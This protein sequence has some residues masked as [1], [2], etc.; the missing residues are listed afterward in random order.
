MVCWKVEIVKGARAAGRWSLVPSLAASS[1]PPTRAVHIPA[2]GHASVGL[3]SGGKAYWQSFFIHAP[4]KIDSSEYRG[5]P[6]MR[7]RA[8]AIA[9]GDAD[10]RAASSTPALESLAAPPPVHDIIG[11]GFRDGSHC[12][13]S[14]NGR[15]LAAACRARGEDAAVG[16]ARFPAA[17]SRYR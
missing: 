14:F 9:R 3:L 15:P 17:K 1:E 4:G 5:L 7:T 13:C 12:R 11:E 10:E 8:D 2:G 6:R 16:S